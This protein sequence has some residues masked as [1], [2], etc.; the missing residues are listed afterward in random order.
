VGTEGLG[1]HVSRIAG[2]LF[3][4]LLVVAAV[5]AWFAL[6]ATLLTPDQRAYRIF[7]A[8]DFDSAAEQFADPLWKGVALYEAKDFKAAAA[9]FA[10]LDTPAGAFN[11][12]NALLFQGKYE[13]AA[14]RYERALELRPG[15]ED[16]RV[17]RDLALA[18]AAMLE[19]TGGDMTGGQLA[20]DEIEFSDA[21]PPDTDQ[22]EQTE[23]GEPMSEEEMRSIWLRQVQTRPAD[24]LRAK[25]A[26]QYATRE[27][28]E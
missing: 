27:G 4:A 24:F 17:N 28:G 1:D 13:E 15:W 9:V 2:L 18:R 7:A 5:I 16:A 12:G 6:D 19:T 22:T 14:T 8:G 21:P 26:Y 25:F 23:G 11:H 10:G 3:I 20:A